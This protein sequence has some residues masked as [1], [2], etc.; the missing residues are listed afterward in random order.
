MQA[1]AYGEMLQKLR[2]ARR[3][4]FEFGKIEREQTSARGEGDQQAGNHRCGSETSSE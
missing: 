2:E 3:R 4:E 1:I